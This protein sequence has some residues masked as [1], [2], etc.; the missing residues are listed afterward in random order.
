MTTT[1]ITITMPESRAEALN[2]AGNLT[3][4]IR[5][6]QTRRAAVLALLHTHVY[7]LKVAPLA[8]AVGLSSAQ[9]K[10]YLDRYYEQAPAPRFGQEITLPEIDWSEANFAGNIGIGDVD[11]EAIR[12]AAEE[13]GVSPTTL[14]TVIQ[15]RPEVIQTAVAISPRAAKAARKG[16]VDRAV[17]KFRGNQTPAEEVE[18]DLGILENKAEIAARKQ[19]EIDRTR[20][21]RMKVAAAAFAN[22]V[23]DLLQEM[24]DAT[25][26]QVEQAWPEIVPRLDQADIGLDAIRRKGTGI[27]PDVDIDDLI[28]QLN[29]A[30]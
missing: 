9:T 19:Q 14:A 22:A 26:E 4:Q 17:R 13:I 15:K 27:N 30:S 5:V 23:G 28:V 20:V 10:W 21:V 6:S 7:G 25:L 11:R 12:T 16:L 3:Q 2:Q 8:K 1:H 18:T 29:A 24:S